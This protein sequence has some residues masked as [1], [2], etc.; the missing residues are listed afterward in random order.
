MSDLICDPGQVTPEW[1]TAC[2]YQQK[3][4]PQG[5]V[6]AVTPGEATSTF[7]SSVCRLDVEYS[8][9]ASPGAPN[10][11]FLKISNP[12]L[13]PGEYNPE[14]MRSE[15]I[16]Y[17]RVAPAMRQPF[18][19]PCYD[20]AYEP[21]TGAAHIL[22]K[23]VSATHAA[24]PNPMR[25]W[26]AEQAIDCLARLHA[27]WWDHPSLGVDIGSFPSQAE[28]QQEW[29]DAENCTAAFLS[30]LG[31]RLPLAWKGI[32][33]R[34]LPALPDLYRRH[35]G[36]CLTLAHG[37]AHLGNFLFPLDAVADE[38]YMLDWQFWHAT[39]GG[40]DLAFMMATG[41]E[42]ETRRN[43]EQALLRRYHQKLLDLGVKDYPWDA[44]RDDYRLSIILVSL[45]IPVWRWSLFKWAPDWEALE[46][47]I[48]AF[49]D[50]HCAELIKT[51]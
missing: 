39:I 38:T 44:C 23:D 29:S 15:F 27:F 37:D 41:W 26:H 4:L 19:I 6:R 35:A 30:A 34:V 40:T 12:E 31:D 8:K 2:L 42:I 50:L 17:Q 46:R 1:L 36:R 22:L 47:G 9:D 14:H 3:V 11:L 13:A 33:E 32:Y 24:R 25:A 28:R 45:F 16:F 51:T 20:A 48:T 7:A 21:K 43:L 49:E 10:R 18:T 5:S